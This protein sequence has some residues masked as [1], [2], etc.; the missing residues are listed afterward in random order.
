VLATRDRHYILWL[1]RLMQQSPRR[2]AGHGSAGGR[3]CAGA[4]RN[5][6]G[7]CAKGR[8]DGHVGV[9]P[10]RALSHRDRVCPCSL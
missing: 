10:S 7:C 4:R 9:H 2:C 5:Q 1:D 8:S 3:A 6:A